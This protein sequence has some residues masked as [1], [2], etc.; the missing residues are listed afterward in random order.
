MA[1]Q[2]TLPGIPPLPE[3]TDMLFFA[4]MPEMDAAQRIAT[5]TCSLRDAYRLRGNSIDVSQLHISI[6]PVGVYFGLPDEIVRRAQLLAA[7]ITLERFDVQFDVAVGFRNRSRVSGQFPIVLCESISNASFDD[8]SQKLHHL[9]RGRQGKAWKSITPHIT[10]LYSDTLAP[11]SHVETIEWT[12][13]DFV[14]LRRHIGQR[15][16]YTVLGR[17]PFH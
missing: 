1:Y 4:V 17:W 8:L 15:R 5:L 3:P 11:E 14:L 16:P 13:K 2:P 9:L 7:R 6:C 12:V 10:M